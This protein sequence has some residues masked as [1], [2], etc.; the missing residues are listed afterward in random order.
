MSSTNN[1]K[2]EQLAAVIAIAL[3]QYSKS[4]HDYE[5]LTLTINR[6]SR[7]YSPW[8]SKIYSLRQIPNKIPTR[9]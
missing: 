5:T 6:V 4:V 2:D 9:R 7:A 3:F 8:S 1:N